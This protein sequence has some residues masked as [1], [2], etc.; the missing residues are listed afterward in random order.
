MCVADS[1]FGLIMLLCCVAST[2]PTNH[3][4]VTLVLVCI[5]TLLQSNGN[6]NGGCGV[7]MGV[8]GW[9]TFGPA[10]EL[11]LNTTDFLIDCIGRCPY[12]VIRNMSHGPAYVLMGGQQDHT[13]G[14]QAMVD[15]TDGGDFLILRM[16]SSG[17]TPLDRYNS[18]IYAMTPK[19]NSVTTISMTTQ[20]AV[21]HPYVL[22]RLAGAEAVFIT[23]THLTHHR[24]IDCLD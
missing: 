5:M 22:T 12:D 18:V 15:L 20:Q 11:H 13:V 2:M 21:R 16:S 19:P 6:G 7:I 3:L 14:L 1:L 17:P 24:H 8:M 9:P 10:H 23:G 4:L